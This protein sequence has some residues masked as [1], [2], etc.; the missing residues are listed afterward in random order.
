MTYAHALD[1]PHPW[2]LAE[3]TAILGGKAANLGLMARELGLPVPPGFVLTTEACRAAL[4]DGWPDGLDAEIRE[5]MR[6]LEAAVGRRFGDPSD[7]LLVSVRSGA[8]VS[9][10]G[11]MD[12]IL[13]LGLNDATEAGLARASGG[14]AFA[15]G[16]RERFESSFRS[17][18]GTDAPSDPWTQLRLAVEAVFRSWNSDRA[19]AYR[20]REDIADDL[21][22]AVT[23]QAMVFGNRGPSSATGVVFTR[24]P[25]TG[26]PGLYGDVLFEAQGEDVVAGTHDTQPIDVLD[27]R[28]PSV[29]FELR[30]HAARLERHYA[31]LCDI[32]FTI[33]AGRLWML[34]VRVGKRSP[35]AALR[36][37]VDM[38]EDDAFPL[39]RA[40]AIARVLPLLAHPPTISTTRNGSAAPLLTGLP[41]SPGLASGPTVT[42][43][44]AALAAA[45]AG[46][47]AILV[48][49]ETSPN[50]V[51]GMARA[52]GI[53]TAR[54][55]L[56]SHAA[57]VARGW[58]IPAVVGA[59]AMDVRDG[60]IVVGARTLEA[61]TELT[62]DGSSGEVFEG[63]LAGSTAVVP[64]ARTLRSWARELGIPIGDD[65]PGEPVSAR[66]KAAAPTRAVGPDACLRAI[67]IKGFA[68]VQRLA[69][70]VLSTP[71][72]LGPLVERLTSDGLVTTVAGA[73]RLTD[74]G[75]GRITALLGAERRA[76]GPAAASAALDAFVALD[77]RL[78]DC[79]TAWQL[80]DSATQV[81]ND[82]ADAAYDA[83]VL[84]R[85]AALHADAI[86]WLEPLRIDCPR[87]GDYG[88]RLDRAL[89]AARSGDNRFVA[90]PRVDS[91]HG[92]WFELHEDL[93]Q[94][95]GRTREA[96]VEAGRA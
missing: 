83:T 86:T 20:R 80:R 16:C 6:E 93:I 44:E 84:D 17:I 74:A 77:R 21:G 19:I 89:A 23:V 41:A 72:D 33:E 52:A 42:S 48:R 49:A 59:G 60:R 70:A 71:D 90:S 15:R 25:A 29:A 8:P 28:L 81:L 68:T 95:A 87:L 55:G 7:P 40:Q 58:G 62:I 50:D 91:Y 76:V 94:L 10:P 4:A 37:A 30:E 64:E 65:R 14:V 67:A 24:D 31:D 39:T 78:K 2:S 88:D 66:P 11:M 63:V 3:A 61:G 45:D 43:A 53:L 73:L 82:H 18:V 57:V 92:I 9:M 75:T 12:T 36:M 32:E 5:R 51:P 54:G 47:P 38:A 26:A 69:D 79:V 1:A 56:A 13:D 22:T 46:S 96:E 34:Q 85:L 27:E 35:R